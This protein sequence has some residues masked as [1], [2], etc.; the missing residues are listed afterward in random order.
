MSAARRMVEVLDETI[1]PGRRSR[2]NPRVESALD[3]D[4]LDD[5]LDDPVAIGDQVQI[6]VHALRAL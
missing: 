6:V 5:R 4:P 3:F 2:S 1:E